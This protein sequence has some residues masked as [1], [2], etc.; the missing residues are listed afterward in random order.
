MQL[1]KK[2]IG[3][4]LNYFDHYFTEAFKSNVPL[5]DRILA[6]LAK[7]KG[8]QMRPMF[9][10][11][12]ARLGGLINERSYRAALFAEMLH[13]S[14]LVHDD[15]I[16]DSLQRRGSFS[17]NALWKS[18]VAVLTGDNLFTK[19][20]LL[21]LSNEDHQILKIFSD[22]VRKV[23]E[24]ELLQ[25]DKS[26]EL[27][28][29]EDV[30]FEIIKGKTATL[31]ASACA[32]GA[33]STFK[34]DSLIQKLYSIGEKTGIAFQ[35]KDDLMDYSN[36]NIGKPTG[37]D[38]REKKVT[39]PLIYTLNN[40]ESLL[41]KKLIK[42][43]KYKN[44]DKSSVDFLIEEVVKN[45]GIAYAEEKMFFFRDEALKLLYEFPESDTR[46]ALEELVRYTTGR[47]N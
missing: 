7:R 18:R 24:G 36:M 45:G 21:L 31:L 9:V 17:I 25:M 46:S 19:S 23:I 30:Y 8:K 35:I 26:R 40:C 43:I 27:N 41:R 11:L 14:S 32:A 10:L 5:L 28:L 3:S 47:A 42:I 38:I 12:C 16:D 37:N 22:S 44:T 6:Y 33:A 15:L 1:I 29:K 39:L 34:E 2:V 4:E 13:T 20:V